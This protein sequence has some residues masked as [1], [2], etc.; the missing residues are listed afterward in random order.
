MKARSG[1]DPRGD[2]RSPDDYAASYW[3]RGGGGRWLLGGLFLETN[4]TESIQFDGVDGI[5]TV[6]RVA[7]FLASAHRKSLMRHYFVFGSKLTLNP[8]YGLI[9]NRLAFHSKWMLTHLSSTL[10]CSLRA[11]RLSLR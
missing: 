5:F 9:M 1:A 10:E 7:L 4:H 8:S 2:R 6:S 11:A 3:N